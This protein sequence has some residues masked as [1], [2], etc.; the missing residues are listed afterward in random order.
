MSAIDDI[1]ARLDI[2]DIIGESVSLRK[3]GRHFVGFC[4]FHANTRTPA[5]TVFPDTQSFYCFGCHAAGTLFDFVMRQ[6]G[7]DFREALQQLAQ[8]A[9]VQLVE[10]SDAEEQQ[11]RQRTRLLEINLA[12]AKYFNYVLLNLSRAQLAR[13]YIEQ[14]AIDNATVEAFQLGYS[15]EDWSHLLTYLTDKKGFAP[16]EV[17]AAGLAIEREQGGYYDRFRGRLIFPIRDARG[18]VVGFGGRAIGDAQPKY[19][20][21][22]QTAL[23]DKSYVLYGLDLARDAIRQADATVIVEGY[24]DVITAHQHGF[25]NVVAPLGTA[26]TAGHVAMLKKLS[27]NVYLALDADPAG[28]RATLRGLDTL[29]QVQDENSS[30]PVVSAQGLVHWESD[31]SLR[32]IKLPAGQDPDEVI[33]ADP[34]H[35]RMLV[36]TAMPVVDFYMEAYTA[37]LD[38]SQAQQQRVALDRLLPIIAQLEGAQQRVY[39]ARLEQIVGIRAELILDLLHENTNPKRRDQ[40]RPA[41]IQHQPA[42]AIQAHAPIRDNLTREDYLLGL[43]LHYPAICALVEEALIQDLQIYPRMR[44]LIGVTFESLL[45]QIENR[46]IWQ[47]IAANP[48]ALDAQNGHTIDNALMPAYLNALPIADTLRSHAERLLAVQLP[49]RQEYLYRQSALAIAKHLRI[50]QVRHWHERLHQ[51]AHT[52]DLPDRPDSMPDPA[53]PDHEPGADYMHTLALLRELQD[54]LAALTTPRR[55]SSFPDL[56]D[57]FSK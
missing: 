35:W 12:A 20:N 39:V 40:K 6:Q 21:S 52:F 17:E 24:I 47:T 38:L 25:R 27:Q 33:K 5:F 14:R 48:P 10:R 54:Y 28:L 41:Q 29:Q 23:F 2:V 19:L 1:K 7:L 57:R 50:S 16:D 43:A 22:P 42:P 8:R 11:D 56:R 53:D 37:D 13:A 55:S 4:P 45:E 26:L 3:T 49:P 44:E 36:D 51:Q 18:A 30:H 34:Q 9:G 31:V 46:M 32:I 15:L